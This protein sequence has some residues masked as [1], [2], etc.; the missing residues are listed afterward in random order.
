MVCVCLSLLLLNSLHSAWFI[1][2]AELILVPERMN[3][4][5]DEFKTSLY[6]DIIE[7][8]MSQ[9]KGWVGHCTRGLSAALIISTKPSQEKTH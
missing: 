3:I 9:S 8:E 6:W 5:Y 1:N 4:F 2:A 7:D